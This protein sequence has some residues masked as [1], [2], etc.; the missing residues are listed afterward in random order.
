MADKT[1]GDEI[2][3][4]SQAAPEE[5]R[6]TEDRKRVENQYVAALIILTRQLPA[7]V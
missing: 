4:E 6:D 5:E 3:E 1:T 7:T 2:E